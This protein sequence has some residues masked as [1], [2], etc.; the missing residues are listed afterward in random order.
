MAVMW[1]LGP[2][3]SIKYSKTRFLKVI[4][5]HNQTLDD[6]AVNKN[7]SPLRTE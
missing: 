1:I 3:G 4:S 7:S 2:F 5:S 6:E